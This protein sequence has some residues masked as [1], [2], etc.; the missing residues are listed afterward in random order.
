MKHPTA[1]Y[2][3]R[4]RQSTL[5]CFAA[6]LILAA[7]PPA[8]AADRSAA[9]QV[10][11][12]HSNDPFAA[13]DSALNEAASQALMSV[14]ESH[15]TNPVTEALHPMQP[16]PGRHTGSDPSEH[17]SWKRVK[18]FLPEIEPILSQVG[19]PVQLAA[20]V[21]VESGGNPTALSSKG[22]RGLWQLMPDTARRYGLTVN[23]EADQRLDVMKSTRAAAEY[24]RDLYAE[25]HSWPLALAAYNAGEQ[26]V[27]QAM[28]RT[29]GA[30]FAAAARALP[31]E[32]QNYVPAVFNAVAEFGKSTL[33]PLSNQGRFQQAVYAT[34]ER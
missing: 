5:A 11:S 22:A 20:V 6:V 2:A 29:G 25:F 30:A 17:T 4:L 1:P 10:T 34:M 8:T 7:C 19:V 13:Y 16:S 18:R 15:Q 14:A 24:L 12:P 9:R 27:H 3:I 32:T 28:A 21:L 33:P 26:A 31:L 23:A